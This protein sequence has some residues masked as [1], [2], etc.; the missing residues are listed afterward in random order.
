[1]LLEK[2]IREYVSY[3]EIL[4]IQQS[5]FRSTHSCVTALLKVT[6]DIY[7]ALDNSELSILVLLD[8]SKAFDRINHELLS[9][10]F[11]YVGFSSHAVQLMSNYLSD[12]N[13]RVLLKGSFSNY[14]PVQSGVTQGSVMGRLLF[15]LYTSQFQRYIKYA[16]SH[17]YADDTQLY[18][19]FKEINAQV[20]TQ[21]LNDDIAALTKISENFSLCINPS[22]SKALLFGSNASKKRIIDQIALSVKGEPLSFS[23][24][25][26]NLGSIIDTRLRFS[27]HVKFAIKKAFCNLK[28]I[29][30]NR[31]ILSKKCKTILCESLVLSHLNYRLCFWTG[32][33]AE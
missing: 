30:S 22:K 10:L 13:Q 16:S 12:I 1:M 7:R 33:T 6:D 26:K 24:S 21:Q 20:A 32:I 2:Q 3:N 14:L 23:E 19:A 5:G 15:T 17:F 9:A 18:L 25:E 11:H 8:F 27:E 4:S 28:L 29:Y 31:K